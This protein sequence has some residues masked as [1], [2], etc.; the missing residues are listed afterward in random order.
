M[1]KCGGWPFMPLHS[2]YGFLGR[3]FCSKEKCGVTNVFDRI[4]IRLA[5]W[6]K[7]KCT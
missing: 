1:A 4:K 2:Q 5:W 7:G 3:M 6:V